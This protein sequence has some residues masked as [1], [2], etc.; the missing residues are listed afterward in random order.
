MKKDLLDII[1]MGIKNGSIKVIN[2]DKALQDGT[3]P[4]G[5]SDEEAEAVLG[6]EVFDKIKRNRESRN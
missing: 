2:G 5:M 6:K 3:L 1:N 4:G